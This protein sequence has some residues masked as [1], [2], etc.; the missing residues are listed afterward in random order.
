MRYVLLC[1]DGFKFYSIVGIDPSASRAP[2]VEILLDV[3][4]TKTTYL[5]REL[6]RARKYVGKVLDIPDNHICRV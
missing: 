6:S 4:P 2:F 5:S 1:G 3:V